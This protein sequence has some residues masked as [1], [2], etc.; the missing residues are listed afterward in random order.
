MNP[1]MDS[2]AEG[3]HVPRSFGNFN[4]L[5]KGINEPIRYRMIIFSVPNKKVF[6]YCIVSQSIYEGNEK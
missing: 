2:A 6:Y 5:F 1:S 3:F 4:C